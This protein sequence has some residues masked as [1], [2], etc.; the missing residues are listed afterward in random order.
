MSCICIEAFYSDHVQL[1]VVRIKLKTRQGSTTSD[2]CLYLHGVIVH[3]RLRQNGTV[4]EKIDHVKFLP[5]L[6]P[7]H[8]IINLNKFEFWSGKNWVFYELFHIFLFKWFHIPFK[9]LVCFYIKIWSKLWFS[10]WCFA[11][12]CRFKYQ[13]WNMS[14]STMELVGNKLNQNKY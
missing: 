14:T 11:T 12:E 9:N 8:I 5:L 2:Y 4:Q 3:L 1:W 7:S 6:L 10:S 13:I